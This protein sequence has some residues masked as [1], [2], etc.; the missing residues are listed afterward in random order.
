LNRP[1]RAIRFWQQAPIGDY[2]NLRRTVTIMRA[3]RYTLM[4]YEPLASLWNM[5]AS[6][7]V[8]GALVEC[9]SF[10]GGSAA[11]IATAA[12]DRQ[13]WMF[14]SWE[15][16]PEPG[17]L[18]VTDQGRRREAGW[19]SASEALA[20]GTLDQLGV[21]RT[22]VQMIKGWFEDTVPTAKAR[23]GPIALLH[24]DCDWYSSVRLVL[25]ELYDQVVAGGV[26]AVD[27][28]QHWLGCRKAVD[29]YFEN[30]EAMPGFH[31]VGATIRFRKP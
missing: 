2:S 17:E 19:I 14:D 6:L 28:Y 4:A 31:R 23:V 15:G 29:E 1:R 8:A 10:A 18:D 16:M 20:R 26:V 11:V 22:R 12:P 21:D 3:Q 9:G 25:N 7:E 24:I 30:V 27:D 5:A 13:L